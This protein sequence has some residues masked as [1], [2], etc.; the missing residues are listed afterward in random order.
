MES[1]HNGFDYIDEG[2]ECAYLDDKYEKIHYTI[3]HSLSSEQLAH[4]TKY[5]W[6][7]FGAMMHRPICDFCN[8]CR[9]LRFDVNEFKFSKSVRRIVNKNKDLKIQVSPI[10]I[11][12]ERVALYNRYH[13]YMEEK[14]GWE[15][16]EVDQEAYHKSFLSCQTSDA[17]E[18]TYRLDGVLVAIDIIDKIDDGLSSTYFVYNP[19]MPER[20]LGK[21]SIYQNILLARKYKLQ[22]IY[23]GYYVQKC[24]SLKYKTQFK[25]YSILLNR[26]KL[27]EQPIWSDLQYGDIPEL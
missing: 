7:R 8:E 9:S 18:V 1:P 15:Y 14:K 2:Q 3:I 10:T 22:W 13:I 4:Y 23:L 26:P 24:G 27:D 12:D 16:K 20:S 19:D 6:R 17:Y 5:G 11:D 25:P 21:F